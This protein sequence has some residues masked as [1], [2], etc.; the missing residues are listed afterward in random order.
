[1]PPS[2]GSCP[3]GLGVAGGLSPGR[4]VPDLRLHF[5]VCERDASL[6]SSRSV[7]QGAG[8]HLSAPRLQAWV[9]Q[10]GRQAL[11]QW[12]PTFAKPQPLEHS[13]LP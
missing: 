11:G 5:A 9:K 3:A 10:P 7:H 2:S 6:G 12:R 13:R 8:L 1:M 4:W